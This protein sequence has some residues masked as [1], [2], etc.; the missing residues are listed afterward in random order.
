MKFVPTDPKTHAGWPFFIKDATDFDYSDVKNVE[1]VTPGCSYLTPKPLLSFL[2]LPFTLAG[3][4]LF[5]VEFF[6]T[7]GGKGGLQRLSR[8]DLCEA[9]RGAFN[10][11]G[12][13]VDF[14]YILM[15]H[16]DVISTWKNA[17]SDRY[18]L[19]KGLRE[20]DGPV[21]ETIRNNGSGREIDFKDLT[22]IGFRAA[23][24]MEL[25]QTRDFDFL[26]RIRQAFPERPALRIE[27]RKTQWELHCDKLNARARSLAIQRQAM[28]EEAEDEAMAFAIGKQEAAEV[29]YNKPLPSPPS[30]S[31][32]QH[33]SRKKDE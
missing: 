24:A 7:E 18:K 6:W 5:F 32:K 9:W 19:E 20:C 16:W 30:E 15:T 22:A 23:K 21:V 14:K 1:P 27:P 33:G 28:E 26:D 8:A 29:V 25:Y 11:F 10:L 17:M 31:P 2:P 12:R 4:R 3:D 13:H